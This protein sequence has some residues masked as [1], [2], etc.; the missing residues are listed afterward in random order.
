MYIYFSELKSHSE[1]NLNI[2][3]CSKS[4]VIDVGEKNIDKNENHG[5][6]DFLTHKRKPIEQQSDFEF[7]KPYNPFQQEMNRNNNSIMSNVLQSKLTN[8]VFLKFN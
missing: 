7:K 3:Q 6:L 8:K 2:A 5:V 4:L 1:V